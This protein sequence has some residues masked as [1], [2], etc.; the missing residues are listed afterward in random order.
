MECPVYTFWTTLSLIRQNKWHWDAYLK[1]CVYDMIQYGVHSAS[2]VQLRSFGLESRDYFRKGS[3]AL[4]TRY[5]SSRKKVVINFAEM[6]LSLGRYSPLAGWGH[7]VCFL[8]SAM[9]TDRLWRVQDVYGGDID[10]CWHGGI[11]WLP[12]DKKQTIVFLPGTR[13]DTGNLIWCIMGF[14]LSVVWL[15]LLRCHI[16]TVVC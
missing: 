7:G 9:K 12:K 3:V 2:W 10:R 14:V 16:R 4:T 11:Y 13:C 6:R 1:F 8:W 15:S 5:P